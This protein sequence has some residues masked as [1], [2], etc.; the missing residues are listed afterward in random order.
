MN[1]VNTILSQPVTRCMTDWFITLDHGQSLSVAAR[2][3]RD[4]QIGLLL[5]TEGEELV[6]VLSERDIITA[7]ADGD[8][9]ENVLLADRAR[10][11]IVTVATEDSLQTGIDLMVDAGTRHLVVVDETGRPVGVLSARDVMSEL[12]AQTI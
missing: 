10:G 11:D 5:V 3:L 8:T 9:M 4:R 1:P 7:L 6:G 12:S 2:A